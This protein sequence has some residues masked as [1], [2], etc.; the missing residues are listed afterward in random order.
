MVKVVSKRL[1]CHGTA[2]LKDAGGDLPGGFEGKAAG[3]GNIDRGGDV[4][5]PGAFVGALEGFLKTGSILIGHD[6]GSVPV[7][8]PLKAWEDSRF[9]RIEAQF[10]GDGDAQRVRRV[11]AERAAAGLETG[12]SIGFRVG[13]PGYLSFQS[14]GKLIDYARERGMDIDFEQI[15]QHDG[16]CWLIEKIDELYE[17]S[18]VTVPMN[19]SA[20]AGAVKDLFGGDGSQV[21]L[22][23]ED[24]IETVLAAADGVR[25][26]LA[27]YLAKRSGD[28]RPVCPE[29]LAQAKDLITSMDA[30]IAAMDTGPGE[31]QGREAEELVLRARAFLVVDG[32]L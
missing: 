10:H 9:L 28:G 18:V 1:K 20:V 5:A 7:A 25:T 29:R 30:L 19:A 6:W 31:G 21:P 17:V 23:L 15:A 13:P 26:R 4:I 22:S 27:R 2:L 14:A 12:L 16:Y 8:M 24:H 32:G 3:I 11:M